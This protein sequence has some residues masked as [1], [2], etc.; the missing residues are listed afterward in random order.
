ML[1]IGPLRDDDPPVFEAAF[2]AMGWTKPAAQ[3]LR[4]LD[5]QTAGER[6]ILVA[7]LD[8]A[9]AGYLTV[10]WES[11]YRPFRAAG[12]PE[13]QDFNVLAHLRRRGVGSRLMD[14]AE[15]LIARRWPVAGIGVG[16]YPDYGPAQRLYV[17]RGY[18]PDGR[19]IAWNGTNVT[20]MQT[21]EVDDDLALYFTKA[22]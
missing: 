12:I 3:Y 19:G 8:G 20:P 9:F 6:P 10:K 5:E 14:A 4:Y 22:L 16:L 17:L 21:V 7:R 15:A 13:I 18:L 2:A 11:T 1:E